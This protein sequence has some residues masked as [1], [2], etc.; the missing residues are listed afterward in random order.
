MNLMMAFN[1][2]IA[3]IFHE[4]VERSLAEFNPTKNSLIALIKEY[5]DKN[6]SKSRAQ[7]LDGLVEKI[8]RVL[9]SSEALISLTSAK[10]KGNL[11]GGAYHYISLFS[12]EFRE[13]QTQ[14]SV[15][16]D[17]FC[18]SRKK[19]FYEYYSHYDLDILLTKHAIDRVYD[20]HPMS[21]TRRNTN[22]FISNIKQ[23]LICLLL[24]I[25]NRDHG[26]TFF[27]PV[28]GGAFACERDDGKI[29]V[30]TFYGP[31]EIEEKWPSNENI[32]TE[33]IRFATGLLTFFDLAQSKKENF[34]LFRKNQ[35]VL[36]SK[37]W[38]PIEGA[39][40]CY[41]TPK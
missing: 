37:L 8:E 4:R 1:N 32:S 13:D 38:V 5:L 23:L 9:S 28:P 7:L 40:V 2:T 34:E 12:L 21:S 24:E 30:K 31:N 18:L 10:I 3:K 36:N 26:E 11:Y 25:K 19:L 15:K 39:M 17:G 33:T 14:L 6:E 20:R 29:I 22:D 41:K 16:H 27:V 35:R